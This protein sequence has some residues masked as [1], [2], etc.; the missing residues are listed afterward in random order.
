MATIPQLISTRAIQIRAPILCRAR[1]LGTS[2]RKDPDEKTE[3]PGRD[4]ELGVH[5]QCRKTN[6]GA[7]Q[8]CNHVE[9][10]KERTEVEPEFSYRLRLKTLGDC[11]SAL[12][13][14]VLR[15]APNPTGR[16]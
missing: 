7:V 9:N 3:L 13:R 10:Q 16:N 5:R 4:A 8:K 14:D 11:C 6:V 15:E 12:H 1:L 2:K